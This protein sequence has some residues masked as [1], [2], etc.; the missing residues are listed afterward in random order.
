MTG[1]YDGLPAGRLSLIDDSPEQAAEASRQAAV[2][3]AMR[4]ALSLGL[5]EAASALPILAAGSTTAR[6]AAE[7]AGDVANV[8]DFG[9][10][11]DGVTDDTAAIQAAVTAGGRV[12]LPKGQ[13]LITAPITRD[14]TGCT[15]EGAGI[16]ATVVVCGAGFTGSAAFILGRKNA[17]GETRGVGM[18][19][20]LIDLMARVDAGVEAYG[21]RDGSAFESVY[22]WK[23]RKYGFRTGYSGAGIG[24][25]VDMCQGVQFTNCHVLSRNDAGAVS[26]GAYWDLS[27]L[28]ES[29]LINCKA[30]GYDNAPHTNVDGFRVGGS[31]ATGGNTDC[32]GVR[33]FNCSVGNLFGTG[34]RGTFYGYAADC[35][36]HGCTYENIQGPA[37][38]FGLVTT[39]SAAYCLTDTPRVYNPAGSAS[40]FPTR[41]KFSGAASSCAVVKVPHASLLPTQALVAFSGTAFANRVEALGGNDDAA[42]A[43]A[44]GKVVFG[45]TGESNL[46]HLYT[47]S[48]ATKAEAVVTKDK[49]H[50]RRLADGSLVEVTQFYVKVRPASDFRFFTPSDAEAFR[51]DELGLQMRSRRFAHARVGLTYSASMTPDVYLGNEFVVTATNATAF[52]LN[53]PTNVTTGQR[54]TLRIR[55]ASGGALGAATWNA[56]FKMAAWTQPANGFSRAID[57]TYDGTNWVECGRTPADVP[58]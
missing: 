7:R 53:A 48:T 30:L 20:L 13:Y 3:A 15:I 17:T 11:G 25:P 37:V 19:N 22:V 32:R 51:L 27:G 2:L 49:Y 21:L 42:T 33:L 12:F 40:I 41:F 8:K 23:A 46:V 18:R 35:S 57:F 28:Y 10:A 43:V 31:E 56:V 47:G 39:Q 5:T 26:N 55:N 6:T 44:D 54:I 29:T 52:T 24:T 9:A 38:E 1:I 16:D 50:Q 36:D 34:V 45:G 58:N 14:A 4:D